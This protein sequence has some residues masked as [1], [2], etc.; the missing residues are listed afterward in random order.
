[1]MEQIKINQ[2]E[3]IRNAIESEIEEE[4]IIGEPKD[5]EIIRAFK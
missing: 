4:K 5:E 1:M 3:F 2:S